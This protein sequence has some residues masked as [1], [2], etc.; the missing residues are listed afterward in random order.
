MA[1]VTDNVQQ[2]MDA[3]NLSLVNLQKTLLHI[4]YVPDPDLISQ[5]C[6][7]ARTQTGNIFIDLNLSF[8][9]GSVNYEFP[10]QW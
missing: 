4:V 5:Q 10:K 6:V 9:G 1:I 7:M 3:M 2:Q 8:P